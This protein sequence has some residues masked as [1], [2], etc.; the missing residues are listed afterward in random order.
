MCDG[1]KRAARL[2]SGD[3]RTFRRRYGIAEL[4]RVAD[5]LDSSATDIAALLSRE[6]D[7]AGDISH[8]L[9][10][11]LTGLRLRLEEL[12]LNPD[13]LVVSEV[14]AKVRGS[15]AGQSAL[16]QYRAPGTRRFGGNEKS[17][18]V[19]AMF[20]MEVPVPQAG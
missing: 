7:L 14:K 19:L 1:A 13:P 18:E 4:D 17:S 9:R 15:P 2:G 6:R 3:F 8:Q 11:R 10:T 16:A 5:V 12:A 20:S